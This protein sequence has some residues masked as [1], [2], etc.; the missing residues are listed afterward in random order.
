[1]CPLREIHP[2]ALPYPTGD[3]NWIAS[4]AVSRAALERARELGA[5]TPSILHDTVTYGGGGGG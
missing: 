1:M 4:G 3:L 2:T 5:R